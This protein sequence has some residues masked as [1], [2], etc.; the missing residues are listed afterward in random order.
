MYDAM[1]VSLNPADERILEIIQSDL[2]L[3]PRPF[4]QLGEVCGLTEEECLARIRDL[5]DSVAP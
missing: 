5:M 2:P 3:V 4:R 1:A